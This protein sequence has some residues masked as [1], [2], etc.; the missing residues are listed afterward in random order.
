MQVKEK[1]VSLQPVSE[2]AVSS[3]TILRDYNEVSVITR[4]AN[5][6][7]NHNFTLNRFT[8]KEKQGRMEDAL[9][10]AGDEG[11]G[12]LRKCPGI[13][14]QDL[15]RMCP[16][17]ATH[18]AEGHVPCSSWSEPGELKHL[19]TRRRR[20]KIDPPSSGERRGESLNRPV[21]GPA[22]VVGPVNKNCAGT[23]SIW[24][25]TA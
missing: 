2:E 7:D 1:C 17:G 19:S 4:L 15:I 16:N 20:K 8:E 13:R 25:V 22:G 9:A 6:T 21:H 5:K 3:L 23:G 18:M 12:K 11:R 24:K 10:S 14:K